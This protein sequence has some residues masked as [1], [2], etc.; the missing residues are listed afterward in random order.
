MNAEVTEPRDRTPLGTALWAA[1]VLAAGAAQLASAWA[2]VL[3]PLV[4]VAAAVVP[5]AAVVLA[6]RLRQPTGRTVVVLLVLLL[7]GAY[8]AARGTGAGPVEVLRD[9]VPRLLS[10]PRPAPATADALMPGALAAALAGLWT[11]T[12]VVRGPS[13]MLAAPVAAGLLYLGGAL[14][15]SGE[16]D[17]YGLAGAGVLLATVVGW[18]LLGRPG[19]RV[20]STGA[21]LSALACCAGVV[22]LA[23]TVPAAGAFD[24]RHLVAPPSFTVAE[25]SPLPRLAAWATAGDEELLRVNGSQRRLRLVVLAEYNGASW[26]ADDTYHP[27]R[28]VSDSALP[29]GRRQADVDVEVR[30]TGLTGPWLPVGGVPD[31]V[32]LNDIAVDPDS[33]ST[34]VRDGLRSGLRYRARGQ[35]DDA[36]PADLAGAGVPGPALARRYL[37]TPKLPW[38]LAEYARLVTRNASTPYEQAVALEHA[39][40]SGREFDAGAPTGSSYARLTTFI[41]GTDAGAGAQAGTSEQFA[42]AFAVLARAVSLPTRIVV[43]FHPGEPGSEDMRVVRGRHAV[44]WPEVYFTGWGWQP[45]DPT[46]ASG[47]TSDAADEVAKQA[48]LAR[49]SAADPERAAE[50]APTR[51]PP[52]SRAPDTDREVVASGSDG[53]WGRGTLLLAGAVVLVPV[54]LLAGARALRRARHRRAGAPGAWSEVLD[55]LVLLGRPAP[56]SQPAPE[57]ATALAGHWPAIGDGPHPVVW[58]AHAADQVRFGPGPHPPDPR[59]RAALRQVRRAVRGA[60][61]WYRRLHWPVDPRPLRRR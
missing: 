2:G 14:L 32:S 28:T 24:P 61:P 38:H 25:P 53:V 9:T 8:L 16:G 27:L 55:L 40:R 31:S 21:S 20:V 35:V 12:R 57:T 26:L 6:A 33:G 18:L 30:V 5:L 50:T 7:A 10:G 11:G 51:T 13:A 17:P 1:L 23:A 52:T 43:G 46:P 4:I 29:R 41:A 49:L 22:V 60:R 36:E 34:A 58:L 19:R 47:T 42:S 59:V 56:R 39:V 45:F 15:T 37:A 3:A 54:V 48:I 44:A